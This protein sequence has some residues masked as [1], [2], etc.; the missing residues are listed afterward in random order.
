MGKKI[1]KRISCEQRGSTSEEK[2]KQPGVRSDNQIPGEEAE[3]TIPWIETCNPET[4]SRER[5]AEK[6]RGNIKDSSFRVIRENA[7]Q[8]KNHP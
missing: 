5:R 6:E 1:R 4:E 7:G 2:S 8:K 3:L